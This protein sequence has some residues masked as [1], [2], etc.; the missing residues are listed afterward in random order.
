MQALATNCGVAVIVGGYLM[1]VY[2]QGR[3]NAGLDKRIDDLRAD[4]NA[5]RSDM[6]GRLSDFR[7]VVRAE[8][9]RMQAEMAKNQSELLVKFAEPSARIDKVE[10]P[11]VRP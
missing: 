7:E 3:S 11:R 2:F 1:C 6:N 9:S 10:E 5:L 4:L 8:L